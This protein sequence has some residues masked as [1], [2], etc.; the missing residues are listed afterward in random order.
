MIRFARRRLIR[1]DGRNW[2]LLSRFGRSADR[3]RDGQQLLRVR[4]PRYALGDDSPLEPFV[5]A[6]LDSEQALL[7]EQFLRFDRSVDVQVDVAGYGGDGRTPPDALAR[8][9]PLALQFT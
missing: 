4:R 3:R 8:P 2:R 9:P 5:V 7:P 1:F 6:R